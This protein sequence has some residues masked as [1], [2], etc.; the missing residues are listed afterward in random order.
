M[1]AE[2]IE[3]L[4]R[5]VALS[6]GNTGWLGQLG[7]AYALAGRPGDARRILDRLN[8]LSRDQYVSPYHIAYIHTGLGEF[9]AAM[10]W[11]DRAFQEQSG[12]VY[13]IKSSFLFAPLRGIPGFS[14]CCVR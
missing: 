6:P 2:G 10:D 3:A 11:L 5:A 12:A 8:L 14:R 9:E 1:P 4:E 13:A 7:E